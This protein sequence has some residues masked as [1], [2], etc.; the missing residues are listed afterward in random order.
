[1]KSYRAGVRVLAKDGNIYE[2]KPFPYGSYCPQWSTGA[3]HF[4]PGVGQFWSQAWIRK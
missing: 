4:E 1:M 2:C 3:N